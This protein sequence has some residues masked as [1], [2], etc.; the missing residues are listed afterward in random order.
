MRKIR[1][2]FIYFPDY[3]TFALRLALSTTNTTEGKSVPQS[4]FLLVSYVISF[5]LC[6]YYQAASLTA[7]I[8]LFKF[9]AMSLM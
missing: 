5:N 8:V 6:E 9:G 2:L 1:P 4:V 3:G 7:C